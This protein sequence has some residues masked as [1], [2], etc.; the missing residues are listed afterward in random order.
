MDNSFSSVCIKLVDNPPYVV[1]PSGTSTE[2][3]G[4][5]WHEG[6]LLYSYTYGALP[7]VEWDTDDSTIQLVEFNGVNVL[8][9]TPDPYFDYIVD[10]WNEYVI[11]IIFTNEINELGCVT[12]DFNPTTVVI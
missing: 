4:H 9:T 2:F 5:L 8:S 1:S 10:A 6:F 3:I 12:I 11:E 7:A